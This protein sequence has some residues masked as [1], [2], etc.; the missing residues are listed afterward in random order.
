METCKALGRGHPCLILVATPRGTGQSLWVTNLA[1]W[2]LPV[3]TSC[4]SILVEISVVK[5]YLRHNFL[6]SP[7]P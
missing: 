2:P 6:A 5:D 4:V 3:L 1:V 7:F